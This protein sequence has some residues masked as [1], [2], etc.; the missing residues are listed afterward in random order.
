MRKHEIEI[1]TL[2]FVIRMLGQN[3]ASAEAKWLD[4]FSECWQDLGAAENKPDCKKAWH[5]VAAALAVGKREL[6]F[7]E[8]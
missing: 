6:E 7:L 5:C 3:T 8:G 4:I 2:H 1:M